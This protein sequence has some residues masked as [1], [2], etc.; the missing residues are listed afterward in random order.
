MR[1]KI[2]SPKSLPKAEKRN[3]RTLTRLCTTSTDLQHRC[4]GKIYLAAMSHRSHSSCGVIAQSEWLL[5]TRFH[6][7][8]QRCSSAPTHRA[9][10]V[11]KALGQGCNRRRRVRAQLAEH[12]GC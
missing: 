7:L 4:A 1:L 9:V 10:W 3:T 12:V 8:R 6:S 2:I 11:V 5:Q